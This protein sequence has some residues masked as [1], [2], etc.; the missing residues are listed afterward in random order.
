MARKA[1]WE[2]MSELGPYGKSAG[3][4]WARVFVL[5]LLVF[6]ATFIAAYYLPLY[7]AAQKLSEQFRELSQKSQGLS[8]AS[9]KAQSDLKSVTAER[10]Q[11]R[12]EHDQ[13]E[14]ATKTEGDRLERLRA[15]LSTKL[16]R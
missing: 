3:T 6:M 10:D 4:N 9:Q 11:L 13:R 16:D 2:Q 15:D 14:R 8:D 12:A 7:R 5:L 1:A